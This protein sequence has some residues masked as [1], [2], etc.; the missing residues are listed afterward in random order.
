MSK[1]YIEQ[2]FADIKKY[3]NLIERRGDDAWCTMESLLAENA[4]YLS[5]CQQHGCNYI[6]IDDCYQ[7]EINL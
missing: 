1:A 5:M 6:L 2:H 7:V 4:Y 3:A